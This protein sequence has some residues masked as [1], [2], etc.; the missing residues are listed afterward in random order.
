MAEDV[1]V[2]VSESGV[3]VIDASS[4]PYLL[5]DVVDDARREGPVLVGDE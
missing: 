5:H 4:H 1:G 3:G 2:Q